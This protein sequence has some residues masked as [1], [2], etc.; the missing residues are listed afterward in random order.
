MTIPLITHPAYSYDFPGKHRFPMQKFALLHEYLQSKGLATKTNTLRP[1]RA[2]PEFLQTAHC[3]DYISRF[4]EGQLSDKE[5]RRLGLPWS[6]GLVRRTVISPAGTLLAAHYALNNGIACH[7]AGGT[8]HAHYDFASG[9]C[10]FNDLAITAKTLLTAGT[11][12]KVLIFDLDVH[13]GDGTA[14]ILEHTPEVFTCSVHCEKNFPARKATSDLDVNLAV[15]MNDTTYLKVVADTLAQLIKQQQ[16]DL[17][18]YD[19][20][21][22]I[23]ANDPLGL[24]NISLEGIRQR[25]HLVLTQ[26]CEAGVPIMTVIGGGYDKDQKALARRHAIAVEEAYNVFGYI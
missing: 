17:I 7:L 12:S 16:P 18:L 1:G 10:I 5:V 9:F 21:V 24:L 26:A 19:A 6:E 14:R 2:K 13:Q 22:D 3:A 8:H 15:G 11:V 25:D 20:G 4:C 23:Y